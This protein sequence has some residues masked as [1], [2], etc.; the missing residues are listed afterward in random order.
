MMPVIYLLS[1]FLVEELKGY[2]EQYLSDQLIFSVSRY[3]LFI[4]III[5]FGIKNF[6]LQENKSTARQRQLN[7]MSGII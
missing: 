3:I 5:N 7:I 2:N 6:I 4:S 1:R